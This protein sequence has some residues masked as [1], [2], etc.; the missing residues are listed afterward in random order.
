[1]KNIQT[2]LVVGLI[3]LLSSCSVTMPFAVTN[4]ALGNKVGNSETTIIAGAAGVG[5]PGM[6]LFVTNKNYGV[7]EAIK[8]G[9]ISKVS[10]VDLK[11]TNFYLFTKAEFIVT[12]E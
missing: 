11:I 3:A 5:N 10:T 7:V 6:G 9:N 2:I 1:M 4:N 8:N 12:G